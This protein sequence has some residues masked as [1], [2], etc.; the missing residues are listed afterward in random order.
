MQAYRDR[1]APEAIDGRRFDAGD[2]LPA[3]ARGRG[4]DRTGTIELGG[5]DGRAGGAIGG[6][7]QHRTGAGRGAGDGGGTAG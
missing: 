7:G 5:D 1:A 2:P 4:V 6:R 3:H